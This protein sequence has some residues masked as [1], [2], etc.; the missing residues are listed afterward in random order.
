LNNS[1][2]RRFKETSREGLDLPRKGSRLS[3][4]E[5]TN[6]DLEA[7]VLMLVIHSRKLRIRNWHI[8]S[9]QKKADL[10][11]FLG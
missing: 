2:L 9:C 6:L 5:I 10:S 8:I 3:I 4:R 11:D 7:I 1:S